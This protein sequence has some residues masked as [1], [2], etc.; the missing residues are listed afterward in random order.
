MWR[1]V[2][3]DFNDCGVRQNQGSGHFILAIQTECFA[4]GCKC[5]VLGTGV[6]MPF[7]SMAEKAGH[8]VLDT[9]WSLTPRPDQ[10]DG[11]VKWQRAS[12]AWI[13]KSGGVF[14]GDTECCFWQAAK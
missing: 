5:T 14:L 7:Q 4:S 11:A 3:F 2:S 13:G 6:L 9:G 8:P 12:A 1:D 10:H